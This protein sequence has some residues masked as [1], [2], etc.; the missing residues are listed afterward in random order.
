MHYGL[1]AGSEMPL[2]QDHDGIQH[3]ALNDQPISRRG[4]SAR[5]WRCAVVLTSAILFIVSLT[6]IVCVT[7]LNSCEDCGFGSQGVKPGY[8]HGLEALIIGFGGVLEGYVPW[9]A[10][11]I[12]VVAWLRYLYGSSKPVP[13]A[14]L[15]SA[16][17]ALGLTL[18]FLLAHD[19]PVPPPYRGVNIPDFVMVTIVSY[20]IGYWLWV[21]SAATLAAGVIADTFLF[22]EPKACA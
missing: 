16:V 20:G 15:I 22:R 9:F 10:N 12:I 2:M 14:V 17:M 18:S 8:L 7:D 13:F 5:R 11:P 4:W 19:L 3:V 1:N 6:Q 21:A